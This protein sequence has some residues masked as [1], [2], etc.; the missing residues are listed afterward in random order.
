MTDP[1]MKIED[2]TLS[3]GGIRA[4]NN[5]SM[6]IVPKRLQAVI[7]PNGAGKTSL[8][9]CI[10]G[11]YRPQQGSVIFS[12]QDTT[13][14]VPHQ[15]A[16]L[17]IARTFQNI[18][19][20]RDMT[21]LETILGFIHYDDARRSYVFIS[22]KSKDIV[23]K[24]PFINEKTGDIWFDM[25]GI[26]PDT[27]QFVSMWA[28]VRGRA[29]DFRIVLRMSETVRLEMGRHTLLPEEFKSGKIGAGSFVFRRALLNEM[30]LLPEA[31]SHVQLHE[32]ATDVHHLYPLGGPTLGNPWG[33]DWLAFY[34]IT[35][36]HRSVP[37]NV[38][39]YVQH[40]RQ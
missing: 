36:W 26:I 29:D 16:R 15:I 12:E 18:A 28:F 20:F 9:N 27:A 32:M 39:L 38:A 4:L 5:V 7:G 19:L 34:R 40:V 25:E 24:E 21:V 2:V 1:L 17:G 23:T 30:E 13:K 22:S 31:R 6:N 35:R 14:M 3:F 37:L 11:F 8:I 33:D 10:N